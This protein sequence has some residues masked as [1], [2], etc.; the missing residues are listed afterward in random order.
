MVI[1]FNSA[2]GA[3]SVQGRSPSA[4][5][6]RLMAKDADR[7]SVKANN[8]IALDISGKV[9]D[10]EAYKVHGR[11]MEEV[12]QAAQATDVAV[13]EDYM[14][15]MSN[16]MSGEDFAKLQE[17]GYS[18]KDMEPEQ[19]V[20]IVDKIKAVL[21]QSGVQVQGYNDDLDLETLEQITGSTTMAQ[22]IQEAFR[23]QDVPLTKENAEAVKNAWDKVSEL[24][25]FSEELTRY[26]LIHEEELTPDALYLA[27]Y[28]VSAGNAVSG[29]GYYQED[30]AGYYGQ[31]AAKADL[32]KLRPQLEEV[33]EKAGYEVTEETLQDALWMVEQEIPLTD[34]SFRAL[35]AVRGVKLPIS[36]ADMVRYG[37]AAM[38]AGRDAGK[39][40]LG[41][42]ESVYEQAN[43]LWEETQNLP[44]EAADLAAERIEGESDFPLN[45]EQVKYAAEQISR[46]EAR[47]RIENLE[48]RAQLEEVRLQMTVEANI[49][50]LKSGFSIDTAP[51]EEL[52]SKLRQAG[53]ELEQIYFGDAASWNA[54][55][56]GGTKAGAMQDLY[57]HTE[58]ILR[59][60]ANAPAAVL[61][62]F[63]LHD[64][65]FT[66]E[67]VEK[68]GAAIKARY[69]EA[70]ESYEALMTAPRTDMG[71]SIRKAFRNVDAILENMGLA[72]TEDNRRAV[73]ILGYNS[74]ELTEENIDTVK[75]VDATVREAVR[76]LTPA[77]TLQMIRDKQNPLTMQVEELN[78][79]LAGQETFE[80][81]SVKYS[82]F[83]YKLEQNQAI[84]AEEKESYL[85]IYRFLRQLEKDDGAAIGAV[86]Q[87]G[88]ELSF[89]NLLTA[90]R[91]GRSG[92]V[93]ARVDDEF[94][95]LVQ[96]VRSGQTISG[97]I[98]SA[99]EA[100]SK[101]LVREAA[102][103]VTPEGLQQMKEAAG[104]SWPGEQSLEE[105]ADAL[106]DTQPDEELEQ[107]FLREE[108]QEVQRMVTENETVWEQLKEL[109]QPVTP[110]YLEAAGKWRRGAGKSLDRLV[111]LARD[112]DI[113]IEAAMEDCVESMTDA[114]SAAES[115]EVF[116]EQAH[117][118]LERALDAPDMRQL[119]VRGL[120]L[121][122]KQFTM[123]SSMAR[124]ECFEVP[125]KFEEGIASVR[126][127]MIHSA[128]EEKG[129][130]GR[131][132]ISC[133]TE[134][135][136]L[137]SGKFELNENRITGDFVTDM[138]DALEAL[139][140]MTEELTQKLQGEG[141]ERRQV[142][143]QVMEGTR[144]AQPRSPK[145]S[146]DSK[147]DMERETAGVSNRELYQLAKDILHAL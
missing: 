59:D 79:Y 23:E 144:R 96:V 115:F 82:R 43:R 50:L 55:A 20:T 121:L 52:I 31:A 105:F 135:Y 71:D 101:S 14:T 118:I 73:R 9:R 63:R 7:T 64:A 75:A 28:S 127:R 119:D 27:K 83:L 137:L 84:S 145:R 91:T 81:E 67:Q 109:D 142:R 6:D 4:E 111:D 143:I 70:G 36:E 25:E 41:Q 103:T 26:L 140:Q 113:D 123:I 129:H 116:A 47:A 117:R 61:G 122:H 136:G 3:E 15:V 10:N 8:G 133:E 128:E 56:S 141:Q 80:K 11:T 130:A 134:K 62:R 66:L 24:E 138:P 107:A 74:M 139:R 97:Q 89:R 125:M 34:E 87:S 98:N 94:G 77:A 69:A 57:R 114:E 5:T 39:A 147:P 78:D 120:G 51:M 126:V 19:L 29:A 48:A 37:A 131:L 58:E 102:D 104:D 124:E 85:G 12:M 92:G 93:S 65:N 16:S 110:A 106:R 90:I 49:R 18:A 40:V 32:Q 60:L 33:I 2:P 86:V 100:Y 21:V 76:R 44:D 95:G 42:E 88:A 45:L 13:Q 99:F 35:Q 68:Q 112:T 146:V 22:E 30:V 54:D 1:H 108:R 53:R 17:E 46:G 132:E 72:V 38:A